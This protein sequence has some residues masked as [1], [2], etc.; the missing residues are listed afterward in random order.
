MDR[1][2]IAACGLHDPRDLHP[3]LLNRR[4]T[5]TENRTYAELFD[6]L[7][8][9]QLLNPADRSSYSADWRVARPDRF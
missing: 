8:S 4:V 9:D 3:G 2:A 6:Y 5:H 7:E 1:V